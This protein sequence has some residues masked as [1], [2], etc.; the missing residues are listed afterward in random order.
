MRERRQEDGEAVAATARRA[1]QV[2]D[3]RPVM[4]SRDAAREQRVRRPRD[5]VG[6]NC[7]RDSRRLPVDR[8][9]S[10]HPDALGEFA[11]TYPRNSS[12]TI[13]APQNYGE[14]RFSK[15]TDQFG[16]N[17]PGG[18]AT[19]AVLTTLLSNHKTLQAQYSYTHTNDLDA[20]TMGDAW[21]VQYFGSATNANLA[22]DHDGDGVSDAQEFWSGT[23][24]LLADSDG[25]GV[26]DWQE[27]IAGTSGTNASSR[28]LINLA[29]NGA[30]AG[31]VRLSW[32]TVSNRFYRVYAGPSLFETW[33]NVYGVW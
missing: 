22:T 17:L 31:N 13:A 28:F 15:W 14:W 25:D 2:D 20:D 18:P 32:D 16:N 27:F 33:T 24:P 6:A 5:R 23:N 11:R 21:E 29:P 3:E 1:R 4:D 30:G 26:T 12:V 8:D 7:L 10:R 19:N 9:R